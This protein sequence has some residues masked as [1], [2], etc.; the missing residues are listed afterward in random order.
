MTLTFPGFSISA[1][2]AAWRKPAAAQ[3]SPRLDLMTV[4]D[5][6]CADR[7]FAMDILAQ[8]PEA[9]DSEFGLMMLTTRCPMHL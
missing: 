1:L 2:I 5:E 8:H 6:A 9:I 7:D 3:P 4:A